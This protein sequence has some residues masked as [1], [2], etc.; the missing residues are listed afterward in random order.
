M[1]LSEIRK[2]IDATDYEIVK[3]LNRRME[4][5]LRLRRLKKGVVDS[6]R[7][8][9]VIEHV[10]R[11][12][13]NVTDP[14]FTERL[15]TTIIAES[16]RIQEKELSIIG[17]QGEH[18]AYSE[19]AAHAYAPAL[20]SIPCGSF[21]DVFRFVETGQ[22]DF[23]IVPVENSLEGAITEVNDLL[24]DSDLKIVGEATIPVHH[25]LLALPEQDYREIRAVYSH[26][27]ALGQCRAF[28]SRHKLEARP[29]YDTAGAAA[30][31]REQKPAA[32]G[33]IASGLCAELY[34]LEILKENVEDHTSN[35][36][37]F[38]VLARE[39]LPEEGN[40][41][42]V[43]FSV[44]HRPGELFAVLKTLSDRGINMTRI[45]SRPLR[46]DPGGYAF[47]L[48]FEGSDRDPRV[49]ETL[50]EIRNRSKTF[51]LLGCY[52]RSR[53]E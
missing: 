30:M 53:K 52:P 2:A 5:A 42:S 12:S 39:T 47:F 1:D 41:C 24:I 11:Y 35:R 19:V 22:L 45:E 44:M 13:H 7:E 14:E 16:R 27:Q 46:D 37:R 36:T 21:H 43:L 31:L 3:L 23:G 10:R 25:C 38:I 49:V 48:D 29:F 18:G 6:D 20:A 28:I 51:K 17:F 33:V 26:P 8:R 9:E 50:D 40:K 15:Y 32:T 34:N 4:Y